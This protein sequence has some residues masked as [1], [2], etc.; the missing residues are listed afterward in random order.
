[1]TDADEASPE[2][3]QSPRAEARI[4]ELEEEVERLR[5]ER[6]AY[7]MIDFETEVASAR[8]FEEFFDRRW[9]RQLRRGDEPLAL[10]LVAPLGH[11][12]LREEDGAEKASRTLRQIARTIEACATRA[13]DLAARLDEE[14]FAV[15]LSETDDDGAD[16]IAHKICDTIEALEIDGGDEPLTVAVGAATAVPQDLT[17]QRALLRAAETSLKSAAERG[18]GVQRAE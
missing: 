2:G 8:Y 6:D 7:S 9:R 14:T 16:E 1:M 11:E 3:S 15:L 13:G 12:R 10:L 17:G 4:A 18:G 5:A